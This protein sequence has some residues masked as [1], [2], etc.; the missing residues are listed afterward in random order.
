[1]DNRSEYWCRWWGIL[2]A[3]QLYPVVDPRL[4]LQV[5]VF[6]QP[7]RT[8][9]YNPIATCGVT[10]AVATGATINFTFDRTL[11]HGAIFNSTEQQMP[12]NQNA[13]TA[14]KLEKRYIVASR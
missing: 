5:E 9:D 6:D 1:M 10:L 11:I 14:V 8:L 12:A 3:Y 2:S 4:P 13:I 7:N